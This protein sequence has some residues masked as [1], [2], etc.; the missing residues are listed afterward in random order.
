MQLREITANCDNY[1]CVFEPCNLGCTD[2]CADNYNENAN[3]NDGSCEP[4][5]STCEENTCFS[6]YIWDAESCTC[7]ETAIE[8]NCDDEDDCTNDSVDET[9]CEC[10]N[11]TI[12][13]CPAQTGCTDPCAAN[14]N[15]E[16]TV[17]DGSCEA[18]NST[19]SDDTCY[20]TF[21]WNAE[22]C[23]C[24]ESA[25]ELNCDDEDNCTNDFVNEDTCQCVNELI[26]DCRE[27]EGCMDNCAP[28]YNPNAT[29][30]DESCEAYDSNCDDGDCATT[31]MYDFEFCEC[32]YMNVPEIIC[33][34]NLCDGGYYEFNPE[35]CVCDLVEAQVSGCTNPMAENYNPE[36]NCD[37]ESCI[38]PL[39]S[40]I[41]D[42]I[43]LCTMPV[44]PVEICIPLMENE[45]TY[46]IIDVHSHF[47]CSIDEL[48]DEN[49]ACFK[50]TPVPNMQFYS[51]E[52]LTVTYCDDEQNCF[53]TVILVDILIN[54]NFTTQNCSPMINLCTAPVTAIEVCVDCIN[55]E[56]FP[57]KITDVQSMFNCSIGDLDDENTAC[58]K[59]TPI[60]SLINYS[61][62]VMTIEYCVTNID[63]FTTTA[64]VEISRNCEDGILLANPGET[65]QLP[66]SDNEIQT[67][68]EEIVN[69]LSNNNI[70][71]GEF[72]TDNEQTA[73]T[74][75]FE[76][77][78]PGSTTIEIQVQN[79]LNEEIKESEKFGEEN[80]IKLYPIPAKKILRVDLPKTNQQGI[81]RIF[82]LSGQLMEI[83]PIRDTQH[84]NQTLGFDI[85]NYENGLYYFV[86]RHGDHI[87]TKTFIKQ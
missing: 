34:H 64:I 72:F 29:L 20:S 22:S 4:Y 40:M 11:E 12:E 58:F 69:E 56:S 18:Y 6:T 77:V 66:I 51:P 84:N 28:N 65:E 7:L 54:C 81:V 2:P 46:T 61:P 78:I 83:R 35:T 10:V 23:A 8:L 63:C 39:D 13:G 60:P 33:S 19:C 5:N 70:Q 30:D 76:Y 57:A 14:Y 47:S 45:I 50:Y 43:R 49:N 87:D 25:M 27:I 15:P 3:E 82:S 74:N 32:V 73:I 42:T 80:K 75:E 44:T 86:L 17:D 1:S 16:A 71:N 55:D 41:S 21:A 24:L 52:Q 85:S 26:E 79:E 31:G 53:N 62:D 48:D 59:Y 37:D 36:A 38:L 68:N 9:T 67:L